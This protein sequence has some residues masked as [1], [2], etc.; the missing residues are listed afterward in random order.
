M[1]C[2]LT[3]WPPWLERKRKAEEGTTEQVAQ[4]RELVYRLLK[5]RDEQ[6][7]TQE[8][9]QKDLAATIEAQT[10]TIAKLEATVQGQAN[11]LRELRTLLQA[12]KLGRQS[13][14]NA[15]HR[16]PSPANSTSTATTLVEK[17][18]PQ[19]A[20]LERRLNEDK[21]AITVN[22]I[23]VKKEKQDT[24]V[25]RDTLNRSLKSFRVTEDSVVIT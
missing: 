24:K 1:A 21:T 18:V 2:L 11:E 23:R 17:A 4:L 3:C 13:Y 6:N 7:V 12:D 19:G 15:L 8:S 20:L 10:N 9:Q 25:M 22:T 16:V 14:S 5:S